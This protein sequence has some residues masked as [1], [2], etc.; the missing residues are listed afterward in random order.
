MGGST[1]NFGFPYPT[2]GDPALV[3]KAFKDLAD[4]VDTATKAVA[5]RIPAGAISDYAGTTAPTG[6][7]I[8]DGSAVDRTTYAELFS[9]IGT[10]FGS[11]NGSTTFN[12]PDLRG[13]VGVGLD[14]L[15]GTDAG[16]LDV[17]NTLGGSGGAQKHQLTIG[18]MA[19]HAHDYQELMGWGSGSATVPY[20]DGNTARAAYGGTWYATGEEGGDVPHNNMQPY[21]LLGKIIKV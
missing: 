10:A 6:W 20:W 9:V 4:A 7:L 3:A 16:R 19:K 1:T 15:G 14:N 11:G 13:R 18:E 21:L 12:I 2:G 17:A 5:N 8:C